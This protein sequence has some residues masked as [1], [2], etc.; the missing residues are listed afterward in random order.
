MVFLPITAM[1]SIVA[2]SSRGALVGIGVVCV[3]W[4]VAV[5]RRQRIRS[6][7]AL[8]V[9]SAVTWALVPQGSRDRFAV[10][11][12]DD[13]S[14]ARLVRWEEG[15]EMARRYPLLGVGYAN[16]TEYHEDHFDPGLGS[17][18]SH[19]IFVQVGA[20]LGYT[21]LLAFLLMI[22]A[23]F[24]VNSQTRRLARTTPGDNR[25]FH[26]M[27]LGLDGA[28][29]GYLAS[30]FFVTVF[31]Y[32]YFWINL[33]M[34]IALNRSMVRR[35]GETRRNRGRRSPCPPSAPVVLPGLEHQDRPNRYSGSPPILD[36]LPSPDD[37]VGL[38]KT[39]LGEARA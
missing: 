38:Q 13:M 21:G 32:P 28:M 7:V 15:I 20:E 6:V 10:M 2:S 39:R 26:A 5:N 29:V 12:E 24:R 1:V 19:N 17:L 11:G 35:V 31:Y 8:T 27:A 3:W 18:L 16:W 37:R 23:K 33:A 34:T 22:V 14:T 36:A 25:F 4:L 30:G 9:V